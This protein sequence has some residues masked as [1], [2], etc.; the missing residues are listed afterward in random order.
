MLNLNRPAVSFREKTTAIITLHS[1]QVSESALSELRF[2]S[3]IVPLG[4]D[5]AKNLPFDMQI[6]NL[7]SGGK[8]NALII[9]R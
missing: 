2:Q 4:T 5:N 9:S 7:L 3:M 1:L 8:I 6:K